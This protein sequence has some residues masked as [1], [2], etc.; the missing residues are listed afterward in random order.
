[1]IGLDAALALPG[2]LVAAWD[3]SCEGD[4]LLTVV[5]ITRDTATVI[6]REKVREAE[7]AQLE[8]R[9]TDQGIHIGSTF[10]GCDFVWV[11]DGGLCAV[12]KVD[13]GVVAEAL[14]AHLVVA[15]RRVNIHNIEAV[16]SFVDSADL[17]YRG[18]K[19]QLTDG[20]E[21][22]VAEQRD[23]APSF[24]P[25]YGR[26][27]L[28][29]DAGWIVA[30]GHDVATNL[31]VVHHDELWHRVRQPVR[32]RPDRGSDQRIEGLIDAYN[33]WD[34]PDRVTKRRARAAAVE[35]RDKVIL[36]QAHIESG[37][38]G[39]TPMDIAVA[40]M[41]AYFAG[42]IDVELAPEE[43]FATISQPLPEIDNGGYIALDLKPVAGERRSL[44]LRVESPSGQNQRSEVVREGSNTEIA[45]FL[46]SAE[47]VERLLPLM[48]KLTEA[49]RDSELR[50]KLDTMS[51]RPRARTGFEMTFYI[52]LQP[53][54]HCG[55][56]VD[57][58]PLALYGDTTTW[59]ITGNCRRCGKPVAFQFRTQGDPLEAERRYSELGQGRSEL[60]S[61]GMLIAEIEQLAPQLTSE[62]RQL[63][64][65]DWNRNRDANRRLSIC[66]TELARFLAPRG[67][68]ISDDV[69]SEAD[70]AA[71][72]ARPAPY[73][74]RW[75]EE[76]TALHERVSAAI[77]ADMSRVDK[78]EREQ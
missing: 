47:L 4:G 22:I 77:Q 7:R 42:R 63:A 46:R 33:R 8:Q 23:Q 64:L 14:G 51:N 24:D 66:V 31:G 61:P 67:E 71:R 29:L 65:G 74:R 43:T 60:I 54:P 57:P 27:N 56:R 18:V 75:I 48:E 44:Q 72:K 26:Q 40:K 5:A 35:A 34:D 21:L 55:E 69:L 37:Q 6:A 19:I 28:E 45:G 36:D 59:S 13:G 50:D 58:D 39:D 17:A 20:T 30:L 41:G 11:V 78:L 76:M 2:P 10:R 70:R 73:S 15:Q 52:S 9:L 3:R 16:V 49:T 25:T 38:R 62:V 32:P 53:C 68:S 1:M 12:V